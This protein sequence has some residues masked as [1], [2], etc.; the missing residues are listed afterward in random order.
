[1]KITVNYLAQVKQ[2]AGVGSEQADLA[3]GCTAEEAAVALAGRRGEALRRLLLD[4]GGGLQPT[5]LLFVGDRQAGR[6]QRVA[7]RDGD[8]LTVLAP[9]AGG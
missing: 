8:V 3:D 5:I 4:A 1:M 2:A 9:M 7:L 6:G